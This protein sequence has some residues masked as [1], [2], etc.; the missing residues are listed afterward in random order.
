MYMYSV[1][2][3]AEV[4][5][6]N[7][8]ILR[9]LI[10]SV[11]SKYSWL[12]L[13]RT[14]LSRITA[15]LEVKIWSLPKHENLTK[16]QKKK[17][18]KK[19]YCGKEEKLLLRSNFSSFPQYFQYISLKGVK[20]HIY[21]LNEVNRISFCSILQIWY[22]EVR[23][24]RSISDSPLEVEITRVDCNSNCKQTVLWSFKAINT[25]QGRQI[26]QNILTS[27]LIRALFLFIFS[28]ELVLSFQ[29]RVYC[30]RNQ[31]GNHKSCLSLF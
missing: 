7:T 15:Y 24:S 11:F 16:K 27:F 4:L 28:Y 31:S 29:N 13:S 9:I 17:K 14:R 1:V 22:V 12:S 23:I 8:F 21:L 6:N 26:C 25:I 18:T 20:L 19:K 5:N 10:Q 2:T 3:F 30:L